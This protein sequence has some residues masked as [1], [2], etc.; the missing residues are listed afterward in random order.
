M[1]FLGLSHILGAIEI[2]ESTRTAKLSSAESVLARNEVA[3]KAKVAEKFGRDPQR[4]VW[5]NVGANG[6]V[7]VT[8]GER[9]GVLPDGVVRERG[10]S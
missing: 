3:F 8:S 6:K 7:Y 10:A 4:P 2:K 5:I 1:S 9:P